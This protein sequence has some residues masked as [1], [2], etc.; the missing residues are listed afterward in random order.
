M[1]RTTVLIVAVTLATGW[2]AFGESPP[3]RLEKN[4]LGTGNDKERELPARRMW[5]S[6]AV[7][8]WM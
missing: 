4:P 6:T 8:S 1:F 2:A 5:S 3:Q 7:M